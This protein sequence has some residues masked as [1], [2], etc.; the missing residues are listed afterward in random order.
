MSQTRKLV[1][2]SRQELYDL[3][4]ANP[5]AQI[6]ADYGVTEA[7]VKNHCNNRK[8]PRPAKRYWTKLALGARPRKKPLPA[9][10]QEVFEA[11]AQRR[12]P[13]ALALPELGGVLL[14]LA[15][16][17]LT[18]LNKTKPDY[19]KLIRLKEIN[20]P[21]VI[22]SKALVERAAQA[23][24]VLLGAL[25]PL[26][27]E[28]RKFPGKHE[29]GYFRWGRER[30]FVRIEETLLDE[31]GGEHTDYWWRCHGRCTPSGRLAVSCKSRPWGQCEEKEWIENGRHSLER[32]LSE[33]AVHVRLYFLKKQR[34]A[35]QEAIDRKKWEE[36]YERRQGEWEAAE[37]IRKQKEME[38]AHAKAITAIIEG[39]QRDLVKAA[40]RWERSCRII[41]YI[42]TCERN[43][44]SSTGELAS[45]QAAWLAW[46]REIAAKFSP[47]SAGY[48]DPTKHGAFDVGRIPFGGPYPQAEQLSALR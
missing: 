36:E 38:Q 35:I 47:F 24:H 8:V 6:A 40:E 2:H 28:F 5:I 26:G 33:V 15:A 20:F 4:W 39:R 10:A 19:H 32:I 16:E 45:E 12:V 17:M 37:V 23:F 43:W 41:E 30:L 21:E 1:N 14:P 9:S 27:I 7:T 42:E 29:P 22:V 25:Q 3:V 48:P 44:K 31:R 18:T 13:N 34:E 46:A 11:E